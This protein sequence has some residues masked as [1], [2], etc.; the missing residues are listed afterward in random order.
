MAEP[1]PSQ[2]SQ[3]AEIPRQKKP[4]TGFS[5]ELDKLEAPELPKKS[6]L[7]KP[8]SIPTKVDLPQLT[9][10]TPSLPTRH[11]TA[12]VR[13]TSS[14]VIDDATTSPLFSYII[15]WT[16]DIS[17]GDPA[18][19]TKACTDIQEK[20]ETVIALFLLPPP[21]LP[22]ELFFLPYLIFLLAW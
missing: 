8:S 7:K 16:S 13:A 6:I 19:I 14:I 17:S 15:T 3:S 2:L 4:A 5:L 9:G 20:I 21:P 12:A 11:R 18:T 22:S 10:P 1:Q